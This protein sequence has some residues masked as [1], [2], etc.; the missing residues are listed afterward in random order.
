M[1][2]WLSLLDLYQSAVVLSCQ[3]HHTRLIQIVQVGQRLDGHFTMWLYL[4]R[5]GQRLWLL[6]LW[7]FKQGWCDDFSGVLLNCFRSNGKTLNSSS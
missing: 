3:Q 7:C 5:M 2:Y 4:G 1:A 6:R